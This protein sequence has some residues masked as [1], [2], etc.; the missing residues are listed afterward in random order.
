MSIQ[1]VNTGEMRKLAT[2]L[3]TSGQELESVSRAVD[4]VAKSTVWTGGIR[5]KF[6]GVHAELISIITKLKLAQAD[7]ATQLQTKATAFDEI[8]G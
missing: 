8:F 6:D 2:T 1:Q 3:D 7:L 4:G 5:K